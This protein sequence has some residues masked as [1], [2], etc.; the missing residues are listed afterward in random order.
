[1]TAQETRELRDL[2]LKRIAQQ[3]VH[4]RNALGD[5]PYLGGY[6]TAMDDMA[7]MVR[8]E[9]NPLEVQDRPDGI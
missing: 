6:F 8:T 4:V 5:G 9:L 3:K 7:L 2:L 1:M